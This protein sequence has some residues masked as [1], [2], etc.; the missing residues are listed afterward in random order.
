M[1]ML[2]Y[3]CKHHKLR[4]QDPLEKDK[5]EPCVVWDRDTDYL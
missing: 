2:E 5:Q 4:V 1:P 3:L